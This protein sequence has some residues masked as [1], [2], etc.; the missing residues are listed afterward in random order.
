M[1]SIFRNVLWHSRKAAPWLGAA[2]FCLLAASLPRPAEASVA[3]ILPH[4]ALYNVQLLKSGGDV[5]DVDGQM[6]FEWQDSCDGW[7][8]SQRSLMQFLY[9]SGD[10]ASIGWSL[11]SWEAKDGTSYRFVVRQLANGEPV[12]EYRGDAKL[13]ADGSGGKANYSQPP[14]L[15]VPLP[16]GSLFPTQ[17]SLALI[18]RA[19]KG[20]Q[21]VWRAVFDGSDEQGLFDVN[22]IITALPQAAREAADQRPELKGVPG[23]RVALAFYAPG[24]QAAEPEHEQN[25]QLYANGVVDRLE[26]N[27]GE[28]TIL[29]TLSKLEPLPKPAC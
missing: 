24:S 4:R 13:A 1:S 9:A 7:S 10:E 26:L 15:T 22:A 20:D 3:G 14:S 18:E 6:A 11:T 25:L 19:A 17:H 27:Y 23:W 5:A 28:F 21:M 29:A 16:A 2:V 8:V 12:A